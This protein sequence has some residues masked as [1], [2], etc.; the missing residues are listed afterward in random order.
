VTAP[1]LSTET[2]RSTSPPP[3]STDITDSV[4]MAPL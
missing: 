4:G 3:T 2:S 1:V